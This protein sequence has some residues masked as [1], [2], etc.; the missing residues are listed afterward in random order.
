M[1]LL[2]IIFRFNVNVLLLILMVLLFRELL[3]LVVFLLIMAL[4]D[5][6]GGLVYWDMFYFIFNFFVVFDCVIIKW[7]LIIICLIGIF[8]CLSMKWILFIL[9]DVFWI[10]IILVCLFIVMVFCLFINL[11]CVIRLVIFFVL[12]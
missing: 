11:D 12:V 8:S 10:S 1:V 6:V 9:F 4:V 3:I 2:E 7:V 5:D